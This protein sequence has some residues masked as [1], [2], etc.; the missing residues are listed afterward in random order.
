MRLPEIPAPP[1]VGDLAWVYIV[2]ASDGVFYVGH[3]R[4]VRERIRKHRLGLGSK[5]T[6]EHVQP[7][8]VYV[9]GPIPGPLAV[10]REAQ[11][12]RWSR[13]KKEALVAGDFTSLHMLSQSRESSKPLNPQ[14]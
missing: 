1:R 13:A 14:N 10:G 3:T 9:E 5:H 4:D 12:K 8:L 7:R 2:Q 11:L 6:R